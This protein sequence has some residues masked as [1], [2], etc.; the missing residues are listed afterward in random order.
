MSD[1]RTAVYQKDGRPLS[2]EYY[3]RDGV[4]DILKEVFVDDCYHIEDLAKSGYK[5]ETVLDIGAHMGFFAALIHHFWP[6]SNVICVEPQADLHPLLNR[7]NQSVQ[8]AIR[9]DG[10]TQF[11]VAPKTGGS[12]VYDPTVNIF[13]EIPSWYKTE[14]V[15]VMTYLQ[16][17]D[18]AKIPREAPI[19]LLKLDC[20]GSE[21][22]ILANIP[23]AQRTKI[24]RIVGEYHHIAGFE[25][26]KRLIEIKYPHL[27][28]Y[29]W[30]DPNSS[31]QSFEAA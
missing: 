20:E 28:P 1:T 16:L 12:M 17:L 14:Q 13:T 19:D 21:F 3:D 30:G 23:T 25:Y 2:V 26:V 6:Q 4:Q 22:D 27:K 11:L 5:V 8:A 7:P 24:R 29:C 15:S 9:H 31:I 10:K 18:T